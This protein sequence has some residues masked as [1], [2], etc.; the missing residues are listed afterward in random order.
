M[1]F[2]IW[3]SPD[4][5]ALPLDILCFLCDL[6]G[7][8]TLLQSVWEFSFSNT[9]THSPPATLWLWKWFIPWTWTGH[10]LCATRHCPGPGNTVLYK[11]QQTLCPHEPYVLVQKN[12]Q[13]DK[14]GWESDK[15]NHL[16]GWLSSSNLEISL[17]PFHLGGSC[18]KLLVWPKCPSFGRLCLLSQWK[19]LTRLSNS[20][21]NHLW[22]PNVCKTMLRVVCYV[23]YRT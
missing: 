7:S 11:N 22:R 18:S 17:D 13:R 15:E 23:H 21:S 1:T 8:S 2:G 14:K 12:K 4:A 5:S 6:S 10:V 9:L 3:E 20:S 19:A 16:D